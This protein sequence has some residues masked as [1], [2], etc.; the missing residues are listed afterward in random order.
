VVDHLY[1]KHKVLDSNPSTGEEEEDREREKLGV[2]FV[3]GRMLSHQY[4]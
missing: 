3:E 1:S 4:A 2:T